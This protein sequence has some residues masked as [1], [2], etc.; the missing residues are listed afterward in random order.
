M[1]GLA[2]GR[3]FAE[4]ALSKALEISEFINTT[5]VASVIILTADE[6]SVNKERLAFT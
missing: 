3:E 4:S 6:E 1:S 5:P 2:K